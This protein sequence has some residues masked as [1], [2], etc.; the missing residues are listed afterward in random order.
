MYNFK[1]DYAEGAHPRILEKL[2]D[3]NFSQQQGYGDDD[4]SR[5][6]KQLLKE[7]SGNDKAQVYFVSGGTQANLIVMSALL[8]THEAVI[9]AKTGHISANETGAIESTGHKVI[10][11]ETADGKLYPQHISKVL[12]D[13]ALRP[14][15]VKPRLVYISN[16][17][18]IGTIYT[19]KELLALSKIC[20]ESELLLYMDGARMGHA[21]TATNNDLTL[22]DISKLTD[23][24]YLGATK[25][26]GLLGEAIIFNTEGLDKDFDFVIKQKGALLSKGRL[27]GIQFLE[28]FRDEL[29][30]DLA[31]HANRM[32]MKLSAAIKENGYAMLTESTTNQIFPILPNALIEQ[33]SNHYHFYIWKKIDEHFSAIRLITS[34]ATKESKVDEFI[35]K[36]SS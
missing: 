13:Y 19:K 32:A 3:T 14:H 34:W 18:E 6:A 27:L 4:F 11:L 25:N 28:L 31:R 30:F 21:L 8:R 26:G 33:L 1:N 24:F 12:E 29:Y 5:E 16:S 7:K 23:V 36:L 22:Q 9:S 20:K 2:A 10:T 15:V 35:S 17:T